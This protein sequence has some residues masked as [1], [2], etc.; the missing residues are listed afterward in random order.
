MDQSP[1]YPHG[2]LL[3]LTTR[4]TRH[5]DLKPR[6]ALI[7]SVENVGPRTA[8]S[9]LILMPELSSIHEGKPYLRLSSTLYEHIRNR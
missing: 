8:L 7:H 9:L 1:N 2:E 5:D 3:L 6:L 4:V